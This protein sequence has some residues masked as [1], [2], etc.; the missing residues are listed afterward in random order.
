ML[1]GHNNKH[2]IICALHDVL[3]AVL[4]NVSGL[5]GC[6]TLSLGL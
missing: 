5:L 2:A 4:L 6:D 1:S 3:T